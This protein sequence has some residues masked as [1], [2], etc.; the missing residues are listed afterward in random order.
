MDVITEIVLTA[1]ILNVSRTLTVLDVVSRNDE[2]D[3]SSQ[4]QN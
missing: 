1:N 4:K 3:K 2:Y